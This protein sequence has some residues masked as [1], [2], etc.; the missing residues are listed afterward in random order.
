MRTGKVSSYQV[1]QWLEQLRTTPL[2][3]G[4][5][6][7]DPYSVG[8]PLTAEVTGGSY[9]RATV[10]FTRSNRVLLNSTVASF[11]YLPGGVTVTGVAVWDAAFNGNLRAYSPMDPTGF[12]AGGVITLGMGVLAIGVD[13]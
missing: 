9:A 5:M 7:Q 12:L 3:L 1:T 13:A 10:T 2:W 11:G 4:L 8:D 6:T